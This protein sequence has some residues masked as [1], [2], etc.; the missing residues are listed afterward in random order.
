MAK[1]EIKQPIIDE[2]AMY[3]QEA[4]AIILLDYRGLTVEQDTELRNR[5]RLSHYAYK[6][7]KN[8]YLRVSFEGTIYETLYPH[9]DG[10]TAVAFSHGDY[11][12]LE[13]IICEFKKSAPL[14]VKGSVID[15]IYY[16]SAQF[17]SKVTKRQQLES[18]RNNVHK[19][20]VGSLLS[21]IARLDY[22]LKKI[23]KQKQ[24]AEVEAQFDE[25]NNNYINTHG[26]TSYNEMLSCLCWKEVSDEVIIT[27]IKYPKKEIWIPAKINGKIVVSIQ[28]N[29]PNQTNYDD[30]VTHIAI[31]NSITR[32]EDYAFC[33]QNAL[34]S[35]RIPKSV[36]YIGERA[37]C[38]YTLKELV[39]E[40]GNPFY[41]SRNTAGDECNAIID[42]ANKTLL[43]GC[44]N[45]TIPEGVTTIA[46]YA[47][48]DEDGLQSVVIPK[49][50]TK[51]DKN[52]FATENI[53]H[54]FVDAE[55]EA[56]TSRNL[57]GKECN[58][59]I[60]IPNKALILG[61]AK[62]VFP[63]FLIGIDHRA[64]HGCSG[65]EAVT[66]SNKIQYIADEAFM[67]C[68]N[69]KELT[70][71][72]GIKVISDGA[73]QYC[74]KLTEVILPKSLERIGSSTFYGCKNLTKIIIPKNVVFIG[75]SAFANCPNLK[76]AVILNPKLKYDSSVFDSHVRISQADTHYKLPQTEFEHIDISSKR[77]SNNRNLPSEEDI[78]KVN[79]LRFPQ[80]DRNATEQNKESKSI[81]FWRIAIIS[82]ILILGLIGI[83]YNLLSDL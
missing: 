82:F 71:L 44:A 3:M 63:N 26:E 31:P 38:S 12:E 28:G 81:T 43:W 8:L 54:I 78:R 16:D 75:Y 80:L 56:Y 77:K 18:D 14:I 35:I 72:E 59:I 49:T 5:M 61:C 7:Y 42:V 74:D 34:E 36:T 52:S 64:F 10:P 58:A 13:D 37:F 79:D 73:F 41:T 19:K 2:I 25:W 39:V 83:L 9:L 29:S 17:Y 22:V 21:P 53:E 60:D 4:T 1:I 65:L 24:L 51:I 48:I 66:L 70:L 67:G 40:E 30:T 11:R 76:D 68:E 46:P 6:V 33:G 55:N 57:H 47:F 50:V 27:G 62:T 20:L 32:I 69:L 23:L 15:G 45:T